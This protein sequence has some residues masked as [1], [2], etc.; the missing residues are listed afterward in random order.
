MLPESISI[1]DI[2]KAMRLAKEIK[3]RADAL[4]SDLYHCHKEY[5]QFRDKHKK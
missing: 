4:E 3:E 5:K 2:P 1:D